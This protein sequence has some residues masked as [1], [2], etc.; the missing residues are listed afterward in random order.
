MA[1]STVTKKSHSRAEEGPF[2]FRDGP[3]ALAA[4]L[5]W[6]LI[7]CSPAESV[8]ERP[9]NLILISLD[10]V[11][12]DH[13]SLHGYERET[14]PFLTELANESIV[15][16]NAYSVASW[17]LT[18]H[19]TM[20]TG[21]NPGQHGVVEGDLALSPELPLLAETLKELGYETFGF[22]YPGWT[23]PEHGF[24]RGFDIYA[25][26]QDAVE[27]GE[28]IRAALAERNPNRPFFLFIHLFDAHSALRDSY[29]TPPPAWNASFSAGA[30][31][32]L[33]G[34]DWKQLKKENGDLSP[35]QLED[36]IAL[37]DAG[38]L[39]VDSALRDW[40]G[41]WRAEGLLADT[42]LAITADH[43]E[44]LQTRPNSF[45]GHGGVFQEGLRVPLVLRF[46][47]GWRAGERVTEI[48]GHVDL[49]PTVL[50]FVGLPHDPRM[51]G[52]S[53]RRGR[54]VDSVILADAKYGK[55]L[56]SV[57]V[58]W[59]WKLLVRENT[60]ADCA[61]DLEADASEVAPVRGAE[62]D[63]L[64][65]SIRSAWD[66]EQAGREPVE[67]APIQAVEKTQEQVRELEEL[68]Y[69]GDD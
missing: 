13:M 37:Y 30:S 2:A 48:V 40:V 52:Y 69:A 5:V 10:T 16:D 49:V 57:Y 20:L 35:Q 7:G 3:V 67:A 39:F 24:G 9:P 33:S 65:A 19:M 31:E 64:K 62:L 32:R 26:H 44:G 43:G 8:D 11:R 18:S 14:T 50:D 28:H 41:E 68:G 54:P 27:A 51:P 36:A 55:S 56:T 4:L 61:Y 53:L 63:R 58:Q 23:D 60:S 47:D 42:L 6:G 15:F 21:L 17:T 29:Y 1:Q 45:W 34:L 25:E 38:I 46:P 22:H 59:P 12:W 66:A